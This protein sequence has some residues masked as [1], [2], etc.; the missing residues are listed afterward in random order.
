MNTD[1]AANRPVSPATLRFIR[2]HRRDV[3][4]L[5]KMGVARTIGAG[6]GFRKAAVFSTKEELLAM[7]VGEDRALYKA[8]VFNGMVP[9]LRNGTELLPKYRRMLSLRSR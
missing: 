3:A 6:Q 9:D 1:K 7:Q 2:K 5:R 8:L 4:M